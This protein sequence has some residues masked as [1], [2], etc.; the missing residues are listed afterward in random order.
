MISFKEYLSEATEVYSFSET[1]IRRYKEA[2]IVLRGTTWAKMFPDETEVEGWH[3]T[4]L[5]GFRNIIKRQGTKSPISAFTRMA[6][7]SSVL[8]GVETLGHV[9]LRM[10]GKVSSSFAYDAYTARTDSAYRT[11]LLLSNDWKKK[12]LRLMSPDLR[13]IHKTLTSFLVTIVPKWMKENK[14]SSLENLTGKEQYNLIKYY[15]DESEKYMIQNKEMIKKLYSGLFSF[16]QA[17]FNEVVMEYWE[18]T[19]SFYYWRAGLGETEKE[20]VEHIRRRSLPE[21]EEFVSLSKSKNIKHSIASRDYMDEL[22]KKETKKSKPRS[23]LTTHPVD[24]FRIL[25]PALLEDL[26]NS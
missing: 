3:V 20:K 7:D 1:I 14:I 12:V 25:I 23:L 6:H 13:K 26:E 16:T 19:E 24:Y 17:G 15:M 18:V 9:L 11:T 2:P 22:M 21:V 8:D 5:N 4:D 10:K